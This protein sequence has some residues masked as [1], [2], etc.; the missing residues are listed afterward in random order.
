MININKIFRYWSLPPLFKILIIQGRNH[1][2]CGL[3]VSYWT[4]LC[5][6]ILH[7]FR[8]WGVSFS[9][10][11]RADC[12]VWVIGPISCFQTVVGGF[13]VFFFHF[14]SVCCCA[15]WWRWWCW[16]VDEMWCDGI[17]SVPTSTDLSAS[18]LLLTEEMSPSFL[19]FY[20]SKG[21]LITRVSWEALELL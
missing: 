16:L 11:F 21:M 14:L 1:F 13:F 15:Y 4:E 19:A 20:L 18:D 2:K 12:E 8:L 9:G 7:T 10:A 17:V 6:H 3:A 5:D